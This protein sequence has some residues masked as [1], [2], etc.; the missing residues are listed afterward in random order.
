M[1]RYRRVIVK[2]IACGGAGTWLASHGW[3]GTLAFA[4]EEQRPGFQARSFDEAMSE[5]FGGE[6]PRDS[7][8]IVLTAPDIAENGAVVPVT[9]E[10]DLAGAETITIVVEKNPRP[11][12]ASFELTPELLPEISTRIA[13]RETSNVYA[14]VRA[15]GGLYATHKEVKVTIGGCGG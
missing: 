6:Q 12:S 13:M 3:L 9:V 2:T 11:L 14:V 1:N 15:E 7:D 4:A 10:T 5:F 8:R